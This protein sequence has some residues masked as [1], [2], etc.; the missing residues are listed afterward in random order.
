MLFPDPESPYLAAERATEPLLVTDAERVHY[1]N[2]AFADLAGVPREQVVG[3]A[4][5][6]VIT[7]LEEPLVVERLRNATRQGQPFRG[8][9]SC[10]TSSG[11]QIPVDLA[12]FPVAKGD[13][14]LYV[15]SAQDLRREKQLEHRL[16]QSQRIDAVTRLADGIAHEMNNV[17]HVIAGYSALIRS[18]R[19]GAHFG[20]AE[21]DDV[22]QA[23]RRGETLLKDLLAF[24]H[25]R[26]SA[27]SAVDLN[28]I[29]ARWR[30][31]LQVLVG[32]DISLIVDLGVDLSPVHGDR[33][34]IQHILINLVS[35]ARAAM[36]NG[37]TLT[38]TT[39]ARAAEP[40]LPHDELGP[41]TE[42]V[43]LTVS[44]TGVGM[45][46]E[47]RAHAFDGN[48]PGL[49][50]ATVEGIVR[51]AGGL[52]WIRSQ[53][54]EG[55]TVEIHLAALQGVT[56]EPPRRSGAASSPLRGTETVLLV[57]DD[58]AVLRVARK[59]LEQFGYRVLPANGA[60]EATAIAAEQGGSVAILV[61]DVMMPGQRGTGLAAELTADWPALKVLFI[62]GHPKDEA[63]QP[64]L[65][66]TKPFSPDELALAI[67]ETLDG[68]QN[69]VT[70][71]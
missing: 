71:R 61:T 46:P 13:L 35:N 51:E 7:I 23:A 18:R 17:I 32:A 2:Q 53:P 70:G 57:D 58:P 3:K 69:Q 60:A 49:G 19:P 16:R 22:E 59:G 47:A 27:R 66:L 42:Y 33:S 1:A 24:A 39:R 8:E 43:V 26:P 6:Q 45:S 55:T 44:D 21:L 29:I 50:L 10:Y 30:D 68:V 41:A 65:Q 54:S 48:A 34:E 64:A 67:R 4:I 15:V 20:A 25:R 12:V 31:L 62:S 14:T 5:D 28:E 40:H 38:I 37:G 63:G 56:P 9:A 36:P 11:E 52:L